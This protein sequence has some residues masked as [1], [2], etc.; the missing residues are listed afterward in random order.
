MIIGAFSIYAQSKGWIGDPEMLLIATITAG[1]IGVQTL[2]RF[3][4]KK[5]EAA[6]ITRNTITFER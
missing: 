3:G 2:D 6:E 1:F 4:D 5:V